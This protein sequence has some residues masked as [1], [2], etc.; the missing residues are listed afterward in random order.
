[1]CC[2][3]VEF[4]KTRLMKFAPRVK[5]KALDNCS[6]LLATDDG[7]RASTNAPVQASA[8]RPLAPITGDAA[9]SAMITRNG[10]TY[11]KAILDYFTLYP[12]RSFLSDES[13]AV[14]FSLIRTLRPKVVAEVGTLFAGTTEVMARALWENGGASFTPRTHSVLSG[15]H[16]SL[17]P[18]QKSSATSPDSIL[19][20]P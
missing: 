20:C 13:R 4:Q 2:A 10:A 18:G 14:L 15:A 17:P 9:G 16:R 3:T 5:G 7:S 8:V 1:M 6:K 19:R 12:V 11:S